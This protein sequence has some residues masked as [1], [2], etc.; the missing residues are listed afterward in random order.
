MLLLFTHPHLIPNMF[1]FYVHTMKGTK[2]RCFGPLE[3]YCIKKNRMFSFVFHIKQNINDNFLF[4]G[5]Q[6]F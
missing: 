1:D 4:L 2:V 6:L 5:E 3:I